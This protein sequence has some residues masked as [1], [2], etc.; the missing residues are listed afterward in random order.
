MITEVETQPIETPPT[1]P[2][3]DVSV[4]SSTASELPEETSVEEAP[5]KEYVQQVAETL[6]EDRP[7]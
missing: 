4:V 5:Q 2:I 1:T 6:S 3:E 7:G